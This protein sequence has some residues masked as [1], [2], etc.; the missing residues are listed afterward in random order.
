MARKSKELMNIISLFDEEDLIEEKEIENLK[1]E[2]E[3]I[4]N[5]KENAIYIVDERVIGS[6]LHSV[7][8]I[9]LSVIFAII[10][11]CNNFVEIHLF[12]QRHYEWLDK[13]I[14]YENGL[15]SLSTI[16]LVI[17]FINPKELEEMCV[18]MFKSFLKRN[19]PLFKERFFEINDIKTM[20]GKTANSSSRKN[21]KDGKVAK[22]NAMSIYSIK[23]NYCEATEFISDK[24]NEIP[25][26]IELLK[27]LK[28][29]DSIIVFD[30]MSTQTKTIEYIISEKGHYVAPVKGNQST[31]EEQIREYFE[32][33]ELY[34]KA[35]KENYYVVTEKAHGTCEQR[36][37]IFI[38]DADWLYK[39]KE[40]AGLKSIGLA[41]RTYEKEGK[42][43][44]DTRYYITD[45]DA[46]NIKIISH[47][48]R[49]EWQ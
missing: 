44:S 48:I 26:G 45:L 16:K 39:K 41:K 2:A 30:A 36:E 27:S 15:P 33:E 3:F 25:T 17:G 11:K 35:K 13:H 6:V 1:I 46:K 34:N 23:N 49:K 20:D 10:A 31:L 4:N 24:T 12:M 28:I 32:D 14:K 37:Y 29:K 7:E 8:S 22:M 21:T 43:V 47:A 9:I 18:E 40:W 38:D 42:I 19:E 5:A